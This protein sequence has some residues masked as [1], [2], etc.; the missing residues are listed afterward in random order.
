MARL[1]PGAILDAAIAAR[2]GSSPRALT[3]ETDAAAAT[4]VS[5]GPDG[6]LFIDP[7]TGAVLGEGSTRAR[8]VFRTLT[9]WHRWLGVS[10]DSRAMARA[11]TGASNLA[12]LAIAVTGLFLWWPPRWGRAQL[13]ARTLFVPGAR[14]KARDFNWHHV[15]GFWSAPTLIVL[16][17][18]GLVISYPWA[19]NLVYRIT[20]SAPPAAARAAPDGARTARRGNGPA[21]ASRANEGDTQSAGAGISVPRTDNL[22]RLVG[23][24][25]GLLPTWQSMSVRFPARPND[26]VSFTL[27]D[28]AHWNRFARSQL[29]LDAATAGVV[30]WEPYAASSLGQK[31]RGWLRFAHTGEL[32]GLAGQI[33]AGAACAGGAM[34]VWT[35]LALAVRRFA[36][37]RF[38]G[39]TAVSERVA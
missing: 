7:Y 15:V 11:I 30:R 36:A 31:A 17:A 8:A 29:S 9:D 34:L 39:R 3:L 22:D 16:T 25:A 10:G 28:G 5:F 14:A 2:P 6:H 23:T 21:R 37:W 4:L 27:T 35:G 19:T 18:S 24:A 13:R 1:G 12:F 38:S 20:G 33:L 32:G 26:P